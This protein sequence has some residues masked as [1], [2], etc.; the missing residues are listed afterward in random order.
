MAVLPC[1][2][3]TLDNMYCI[4]YSELQM[5]NTPPSK[6]EA[7]F[8]RFFKTF[9]REKQCLGS[10]V[11]ICICKGNQARGSLVPYFSVLFLAF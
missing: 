10:L 6:R 1:V 2:V 8:S 3:S 9:E 7:Y 11:L 5:I 4:S